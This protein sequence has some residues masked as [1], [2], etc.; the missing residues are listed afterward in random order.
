MVVTILKVEHMFDQL[1]HCI[2]KIDITLQFKV[3]ISIE[4][5]SLAFLNSVAHAKVPST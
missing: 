4:L 5:N 3:Q 1:Y 2:T